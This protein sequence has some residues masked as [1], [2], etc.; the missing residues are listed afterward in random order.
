[1]PLIRKDLSDIRRVLSCFSYQ[2]PG[3]HLSFKHESRVFTQLPLGMTAQSGLYTVTIARPVEKS[4]WVTTHKAD[5]IF[6]SL[7]ESE[8]GR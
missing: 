4:L 8:V 5:S 2:D 7:G 1:M 3:C 6:M